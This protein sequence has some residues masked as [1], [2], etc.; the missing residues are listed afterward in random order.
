MA[1]WELQCTNWKNKFT[2][3]MIGEDLEDYYLPLRT[4]FPENGQEVE[5]P[6]CSYKAMSSE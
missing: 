2:Y 6:N 5:G 3:M 1:T 4:L